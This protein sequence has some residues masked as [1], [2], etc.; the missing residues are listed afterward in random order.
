LSHALLEVL[1]AEYG[2]KA[3]FDAD[4]A[5]IGGDGGQGSVSLASGEQ[6]NS[7]LVVVASGIDSN[8]LLAPLGEA[9]PIQPMK[10]YSFEMP[11]TPG[12]PELSVTDA[13]RRLVFT[14]LGDR[15]RVAGIAELG[16][17]THTIDTD[18]IAWLIEAA[19][20][21][22]PEGGNYAEAGQF[23]TGL[24]PTTPRSQPIIGRVSKALA[25]NT[26]HGALG[27]TLAMG[28]G[29]RLADLLAG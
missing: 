15:M 24:R 9:A 13:K 10:G 27:W 16:N 17:W 3:R 28:S 5:A 12:S 6:L 20:E 21:C 19:R 4:V 7:D 14:N 29:E 26:G 2:V 22:L 18:R 8:R 11:L 25:I 1:T 23:W